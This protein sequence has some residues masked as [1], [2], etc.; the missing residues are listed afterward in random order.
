[1]NHRAPE[2]LP[3][4]SGAGRG[5]G[6]GAGLGREARSG[7]S[8]LSL[9]PSAF[10]LALP[11]SLQ[12]HCPSIY[13]FSGAP[14]PPPAAHNLESPSPPHLLFLASH[15]SPLPMLLRTPLLSPAS[16]HRNNHAQNIRL[17]G[18]A[19]LAPT[20]V[21]GPELARVPPASCSLPGAHQSPTLQALWLTCLHFA[22]LGQA[23]RCHLGSH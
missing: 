15:P 18:Q 6:T 2:A 19:A 21:V 12:T 5:G 8:D 13:P 22:Q 14:A 23:Q 16:H 3:F 7:P 4:P 11:L 10:A 20:L 1:M 9:P 17:H